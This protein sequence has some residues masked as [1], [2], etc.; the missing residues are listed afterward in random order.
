MT[1]HEVIVFKGYE[2]EV[3]Q[4]IHIDDGF[5]R[6][7]WLVIGVGERKIKLRCPVSGVEIEWEKPFFLAEKRRQEEWPSNL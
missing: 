6:G 7:D 3:G 2:L 5:R 4:K 1:E